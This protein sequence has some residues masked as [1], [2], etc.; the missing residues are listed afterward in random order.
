MKTRLVPLLAVVLVGVGLFARWAAADGDHKTIQLADARLKV[1]INATDGDAGL[2]LFA[3]NEDGWNNLELLD[4]EGKSLVNIDVNGRAHDWGLTEL[5][6]ESSEPSFD[7][8]PL[9][10]FKELF[11][12]GT[13]RF[14]GTT[15][16]GDSLA[17]TARLTHDFPDGPHITAPTEDQQVS[18]DSDLTISWDPVTTPRGIDI[19]DYE[20]VVEEGDPAVHT[21]DVTVPSDTTSMT[22]P[23]AFLLRDRD[24]K[25]EV[26]A[27]ERGGNQTLTEVPFTT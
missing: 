19:T 16:N 14:Q 21:F 6:S 9:A 18:A 23:A 2:Q 26:L 10:R 13:Y 27:I 24:Y 12:E 8:F 7:E 15:V 22:V 3:D 5:F 20:I 17:G 11:P 1:E 4:P 25:V